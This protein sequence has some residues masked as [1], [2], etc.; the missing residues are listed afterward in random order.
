M[1][2]C[3]TINLWTFILEVNGINI[4]IKEDSTAYPDF[5]SSQ[6]ISKKIVQVKKKYCIILFFI[7][8][9]AFHFEDQQWN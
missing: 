1:Q 3:K 5:F 6:F 2:Y 8:F 7:K 9:L 4:I